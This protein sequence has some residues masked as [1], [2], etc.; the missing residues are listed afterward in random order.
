MHS[1][2]LALGTNLGNRAENIREACRFIE[3]RIGY[4]L[5]FSGNFT[6]QPV[7][8]DSANSFLNAAVEVRTELAPEEILQQT[9]T[10]EREMGRTTKSEAGIYHDRVIDIDLLLYDELT[11]VNEH[12]CLP[13]PR[14]TERRFVLEP[15]C[16][17]IPQRKHPI[18]GQTF[19]T[20]LQ[21]LNQGYIKHLTKADDTP[22]IC[23]ALNRLL[24]Q[25]TSS[26]RPIDSQRLTTL[27]QSPSTHLYL[28]CDELGNWAGMATLCIDQLPTGN[29]AW[30]EDV[31]VEQHYRGRGYARQLIRHLIQQAQDWGVKSINLTS[32]PERVAAN[33]LYQSEG[34]KPR[35]TNIYRW[36]GE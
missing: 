3:E 30:I 35:N 9:Q 19:H 20:L 34:F 14:M 31:V 16:Q 10:I 27:L 32:R 23:A 28:L 12:L 22:E 26:A 5:S 25:L 17:I 29:K 15:L 24:P 13:H 7:G 11:M 1:L 4:I 18:L 36:K 8:F 33:L 6:T 21:A 2:V